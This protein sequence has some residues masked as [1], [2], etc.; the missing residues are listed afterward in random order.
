MKKTILL[1]LLLVIGVIF[2]GCDITYD[3]QKDNS[4]IVTI[5]CDDGDVDDFG[6]LY[7]FDEGDLDNDKDLEDILDDIL[8]EYEIEGDIT[9]KSLKR[10]R[11]DNFTL[12]FEYIPSDD[13]DDVIET[14]DMCVNTAEEL[15]DAYA[16]FVYD[17]D[18]MDVYDK[19]FSEEVDDEEVYVYDKKGDELNDKDMEE[20]FEKA[21]LDK[22]TAAFVTVPYFPGYDNIFDDLKVTVPGNIEL[23]IGDEDIEV[24]DGAIVSETTY[25]VIYGTSGNFLTVLLVI[26]LLAALGV[27]GYFAYD[28]FIAKKSNGLDTELDEVIE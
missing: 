20:Y 26:L 4:V 10:D 18:F 23:I 13:F 5:E 1:V 24:E 17:D 19:E 2:A 6:E 21:K 25:L 11:N 28:K 27:G 9:V 8:D 14:G 12:V 3:I 15:L 22:L 16:D 7:D